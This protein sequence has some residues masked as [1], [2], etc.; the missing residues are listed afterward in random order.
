[1][2]TDFHVLP[3]LTILTS[4]LCE[5]AVGAHVSDIRSVH[6]LAEFEEAFVLNVVSL[7]QRTLLT[8]LRL[9]R[10]LGS[11]GWVTLAVRI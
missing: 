3:V 11:E 4:Y 1:M 5:P 6:W 2:H 10:E 9:D 7:D 8:F